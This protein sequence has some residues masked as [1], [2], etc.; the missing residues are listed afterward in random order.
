MDIKVPSA[1]ERW[2]VVLKY[3]DDIRFGPAYYHLTIRDGRSPNADPQGPRDQEFG[4]TAKLSPDDRYLIVEQW[5]SLAHPDTVCLLLDLEQH[6]QSELLHIGSGFLR[7]AEFETSAT[8]GLQCRMEIDRFVG[9]SAWTKSS[10]QV[11]IDGR[12]WSPIAW[13]R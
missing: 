10:D 7:S 6:R 4:A 9:G 1:G 12:S 3:V 5:L 8:Q 13:W 11:G 2:E